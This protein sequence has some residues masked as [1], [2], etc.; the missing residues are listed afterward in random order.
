MK[1][2]NSWCELVAQIV[3]V[4][5]SRE[6]SKEGSKGGSSSTLCRV[7]EADDRCRTHGLVRREAWG[8]CE[9]RQMDGGISEEGMGDGVK[10]HLLSWCNQPNTR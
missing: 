4:A 3:R 7:A 8:E 6:G 9:W 5:D 10:T 1:R 2:E